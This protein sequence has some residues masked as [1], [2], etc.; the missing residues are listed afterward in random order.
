MSKKFKLAPQASSVPVQPAN[1]D[2]CALCQVPGGTLISPSAMGYSSLTTNLC[3]LHELNKV[4]L[5][6]NISRLDDGD[7]M[8]ETLVSHKAKWHKA[9]YVM[10]NA[11][12]VERARR[13]QERDCQEMD[14]SPLKQ[15]LRSASTP[16]CPME[17]EE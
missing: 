3:S 1:W 12:K 5:N 7:G 11:T 8:E 10:C 14:H 15:H 16:V 2:I 4:P 9:C 17:T 13:M 6:M